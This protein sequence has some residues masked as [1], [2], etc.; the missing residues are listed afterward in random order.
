MSFLASFLSLLAIALLCFAFHATGA[1]DPQPAVD[2]FS[3][4][5][6]AERA[7]RTSLLNEL[8]GLVDSALF[9]RGL[10]ACLRVADLG[11]LRRIVESARRNPVTV[12]GLDYSLQE[13]NLLRHCK[14]SLGVSAG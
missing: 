8:D 11:P 2:M 7:E 5:N 14:S 10:W 3:D 12:P 13:S 4:D 6:E 9:S 1:M